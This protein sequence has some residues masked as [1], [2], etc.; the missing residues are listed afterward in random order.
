MYK[1]LIHTI[2]LKQLRQLLRLRKIIISDLAAERLNL[3]MPLVEAD[4]RRVDL[5]N[6]AES[7]ADVVRVT[8]IVALD[9]ARSV[10]LVWGVEFG[11]CGVAWPLLVVGPD[12]IYLLN[13]TLLPKLAGPFVP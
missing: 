8:A 9:R 2:T 7:A 11:A 4:I 5:L 10:T 1:L 12:A 6:R 13:Q 3:D